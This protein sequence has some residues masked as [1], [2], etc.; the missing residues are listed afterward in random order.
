[1]S[2]LKRYIEQVKS[3]I[4]SHSPTIQKIKNIRGFYS[5]LLE[6]DRE[7][8]GNDA[9]K[10]SIARQT[11]TLVKRIH[12]PD[13]N[14]NPPMVSTVFY[15]GPGCG[16]TTIACKLAK[17]WQAMGLLN[18]PPPAKNNTINLNIE[19]GSLWGYDI[20]TL[21]FIFLIIYILLTM[22]LIP[23]GKWMYNNMSMIGWFIIIGILLSILFFW[24]M[25][26][27]WKWA[28]RSSNSSNN[29]VNNA[30]N[31]SY[32]DN[33]KNYTSSDNTSTS[34]N[35]DNSTSTNPEDLDQIPPSNVRDIDLV[36]VVSREDF[37]GRYLGETDKKTKELLQK[38]KRQGKVLFCDEFYTLISSER[39]MYGLEAAGVLVRF[40]SENP[41]FPIIIAGYKENL[42]N[43][44]FYHQPGF[45]RRFA[46]HFECDKLSPEDIYRIFVKQVIKDGWRLNPREE[47]EIHD[48]IINNIDAFPSLGGDTERLLNY[49][50]TEYDNDIEDEE[51]APIKFLTCRHVRKAIKILRSNNINAT[52][53]SA[54][55]DISEATLRRL[56]EGYTR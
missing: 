30:S 48:E 40:L 23:T 26:I 46:W 9:I 4:K 16:K 38:V 18:T 13:G 29:T 10:D 6:I 33:T 11:R 37:V 35:S 3:K 7:I 45:V 22:A 34:K 53:T 31:N 56:L 28:T 51:E 54:P 52:R 50:Q 14:K 21:Y 1:M 5:A 19:N 27:V 42:Q 36:E 39:D 49:A 41:D 25:W 12:S 2:E 43:T 44:I 17:L 20:M 32:T 8:I 47:K 24:G 55:P 15:G